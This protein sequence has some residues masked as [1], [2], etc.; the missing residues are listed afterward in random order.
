MM[1]SNSTKAR[2]EGRPG[3]S[4]SARRSAGQERAVGLAVTRR[5]A[6]CN[7][8][9]PESGVR[10]GVLVVMPTDLKALVDPL[11]YCYIWR[12]TISVLP[13]EIACGAA[14]ASL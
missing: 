6:S 12:R 7:A 4:G 3:A 5:E 14:M 1:A 9:A 11:L 13:P 2:V 8:V 10:I